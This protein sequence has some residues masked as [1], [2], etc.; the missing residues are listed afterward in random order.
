MQNNE[1]ITAFQLAMITVA[2]M[3][4]I[5]FLPALAE[6]G[7]S[8][9]FYFVLG[10]IMF[11]IPSALVSAELAAA[12]PGRGG[13]YVWVKEALGGRWGFLAIWLQFLVNIVNMPAFL[14]FVAATFAYVFMPQ[15]ANNKYF[16]IAFLLIV[17]W[18]ATFI[19]FT[20]MKTAGWIN[21]FG[22]CTSVFIPV[23]LI[24]IFGAVWL[25]IGGKSE[26]V[27]S[28]KTL[29]PNFKH[30]KVENLAFLAGMLFSFGGL[31][32]SGSHALDVKDAQK[33]YPKG[34]FLAA[35][36]IAF[37]GLSA[38]SV[39]IVVPQQQLSLIAGIMQAFTAFFTK[40]H[41]G[42]AVPILALL[43]VLGSIATTNS[44]IIG[45]S[46]G[47]FGSATGGEIPPILTKVNKHGMPINM[48]IFQGII[49]SIITFVF[50]ST[51]SV[52]SAYWFIMEVVSTLYLTMYILLFVS[53]IVLRYK[54]PHTNRPYKIPGKNFG[55]WLA[56]SL[57]LISVT[58]GIVMAFVPPAQLKM[59]HILFREI[60]IVIGIIILGGL[61]LIIYALRKPEWIVDA[62]HMS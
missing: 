14:S 21:T 32:T 50:L 51:H 42:W 8:C 59:G 37:I 9:I 41:M 35:I 28:F 44:T 52:S 38:L 56:A 5:R 20:G 34:I 12:W 48:F 18:S 26:I 39:A 10:V 61:G 1:K 43:I 6:Y 17:F 29:I 40:F 4:S 58:F 54:Q 36:I 55:M 15:L 3:A 25:I 53:G 49:F 57:G 22:A 47:L 11:L 19:S 46:K 31:E 7:F 30:I 13:V 60:S 45:P 24:L 62:D 33:N 2:F 23:G 27:L 16:L